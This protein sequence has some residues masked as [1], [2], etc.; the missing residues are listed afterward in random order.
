MLVSDHGIFLGEHDWTGKGPSLLHPEL[1]HVPMLLRDPAGAG[2]GTRTG[3]FAS[4]HDV[5]PTLA[6]R[7]GLD[8]PASFEGADLSPL[9]EGGVPAAA[10]PYAVGG[11]GNHSYVRDGRWAYMTRNDWDDDRLFDVRAD[12]LERRNL[13][14]DR[15]DVV[16]TMRSRVRKAAGGRPPFYS[17]RAMGARPRTRLG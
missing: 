13:A 9:L 17:E 1:I 14:A 10:R 15:P 11:Y 16:R 2:A 12:R 4:T 3:W 7:A 6:S 8:R 5:A